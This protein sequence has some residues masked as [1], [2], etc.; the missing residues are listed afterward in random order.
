MGFPQS[1]TRWRELEEIIRALNDIGYE[2]PLS[3]E[4]EDSG[5]ERTFGCREACEFTK[6]L[7]FSPSNAHSMPHLT[8]VIK[9]RLLAATDHGLHALSW[10]SSD[11]PAALSSV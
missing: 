9:D 5:M 10:S 3:I 1:R 6:R 2:G 11:D 4:W 8:K 7:D